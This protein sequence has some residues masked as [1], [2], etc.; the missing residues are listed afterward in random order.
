MTPNNI[1]ELLMSLGR[2]FPARDWTIAM[3]VVVLVFLI[4]VAYAS[5]LFIGLRWGNLTGV[6]NSTPE[7]EEVVTRG[8]LTS[9][10][11]IYRVRKANFESGN[12]FGAPAA[13]ESDE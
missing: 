10:L 12:F 3:S 7:K 4:L 6:A 5:Y 2:P 9:V 8:E 13:L 11:E 1:K